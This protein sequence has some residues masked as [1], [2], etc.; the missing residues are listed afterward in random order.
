MESRTR[1]PDFLETFS[2][3]SERTKIVST[4]RYSQSSHFR[5]RPSP[6]NSYRKR[7]RLS[8]QIIEQRRLLAGDLGHNFVEAEDVDID[9]QV[10]ANDASLVIDQLVQV[11]FG[12]Q[13]PEPDDLVF[14]DV[15]DSGAVSS[16]DALRIINQLGSGRDMSELQ[17]GIDLLASSILSETLP[18]GINPR[19]AHAWL[20]RLQERFDVPDDQRGPFNHLDRNQN[21]E[22]VQGEI[23][24]AIWQQ[25]EPRDLNADEALTDDELQRSRASEIQVQL[26]VDES[27]QALDLL[28]LNASNS[29]SIDE[30]SA[31]TWSHIQPADRNSDQEVSLAEIELA[32]TENESNLRLPNATFAFNQLDI[33]DDGLVDQSELTV[34]TWE[35]VGRANTDSDNAL[36][37]AELTTQRD[38]D[39]LDVRGPQPDVSFSFLDVNGS[40]EL[41]QTELT[42]PT[43]DAI[44]HAD[45]DESG[46]VSLIEIENARTNDEAALDG[47]SSSLSQAALNRLD[48][49]SDDALE[50]SELRPATWT[51]IVGLDTNND[52]LITFAELDAARQESAPGPITLGFDIDGLGPVQGANRIS[53]NV[54]ET[55]TFNIYVLGTGDDTRIEEF[56]LVGFGIESTYGT[57]FGQ[58][59]GATVNPDIQL[60]EL[61]ETDTPGIVRLSGSSSQFGVPVDAGGNNHLLLGSIMFE[62]TAAGTTTFAFSDLD[63]RP[64]VADFS[65]GD[66]GFSNIDEDIFRD[67]G[68]PR[69]LNFMIDT[70]PE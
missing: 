60:F 52:N 63:T 10:S 2:S 35:L 42:V 21:Q 18:S 67:N 7:R 48:L 36:S 17:S 39:E 26:P 62:A 50:E 32:R 30:V 40:D 51:R 68:T 31:L 59:T 38:I 15:D 19:F 1:K 24:D 46:S 13:T 16:I 70:V 11:E 29:L 12:Q 49:N 47:D 25:L 41:E 6:L 9:G 14:S 8:I 5:T 4:G 37:L 33:D 3:K 23:D 34:A 44:E 20:D 61:N 43:W 57:D 22:I 53:V 45:A 58:V 54:G 66:D 69:T 64:T 55:V 65:L 56:G 27:G 28:D